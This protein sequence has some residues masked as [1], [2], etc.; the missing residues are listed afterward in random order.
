MIIF[1]NWSQSWPWT[2]KYRSWS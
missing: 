2:K 1:S